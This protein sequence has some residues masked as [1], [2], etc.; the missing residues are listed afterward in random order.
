[1]TTT[2]KTKLAGSEITEIARKYH[3]SNGGDYEYVGVR[4]QE[5]PFEIGEIEH[6]SKVWIDGEETEELLDGISV[7]DFESEMVIMH[8]VDH[9]TRSGY[10]Y[11]E[12]IAI[13][14]GNFATYGQDEGEIIINNAVVMEVIS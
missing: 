4:T 6:L 10:Y 13:V 14:C 9:T 11:G 7:T 1:M 8:G 2:M 3:F 5:E 12:H